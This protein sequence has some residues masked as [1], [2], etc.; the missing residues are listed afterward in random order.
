MMVFIRT[1]RN[2]TIISITSSEEV[3][4]GVS[5]WKCS[6][7]TT[8][9]RLLFALPRSIPILIHD[10]RRALHL[11]FIIIQVL[12]SYTL[13]NR[14]PKWRYRC[15][16]LQTVTCRTNWL[17]HRHRITVTEFSSKTKC[18][19]YK[20]ELLSNK[21]FPIALIYSMT[22]LFRETS[23]RCVLIYKEASPL[24]I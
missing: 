14:T 16:E 1:E 2:T 21:Q 11:L 7:R 20:I 9:A 19:S 8:P 3:D 23:V 18:F 15:T 5:Q 17:C 24:V 10:C 4:R 22:I 6:F 12:I 13:P